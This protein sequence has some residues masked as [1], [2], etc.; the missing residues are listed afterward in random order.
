MY[1]TFTW[2]MDL[3]YETALATKKLDASTKEM[4][5]FLSI[6]LNHE[7]DNLNLFRFFICYGVC[8]VVVVDDIVAWKKNR[9]VARWWWCDVAKTHVLK[10][11]HEWSKRPMSA[12]NINCIVWLNFEYSRHFESSALTEKDTVNLLVGI[13]LNIKLYACLFFHPHSI[14]THT[15]KIKSN[16]FFPFDNTLFLKLKN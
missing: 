3:S 7:Y 12:K 6:G 4:N 5:N 16:F 14:S 10:W 2:R 8:V 1:E 11:C 15:K 9:M 13:Q